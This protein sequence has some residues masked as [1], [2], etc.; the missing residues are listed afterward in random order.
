[1]SYAHPYRG[2]RVLDLGQGVAAPYCAQLLA[3]YGA[4]VIKVEPPEG[5]WGRSLGSTYAGRQ[6]AV[7]A[8]FNRGKK[9]LVLD[10]RKDEARAVARRLALKADILIEGF[11]PGVAARL[12]LGYESLKAENPKLL[13]VSVSGFGQQGPYAARPCSDSAAQAFSGLIHAA[14]GPDGTPHKST[15]ILSDVSTGLYAYQALAT[16]LYARRDA[17]EGRWIDVSLMTGSAA[18]LGHK[19][20][21]FMLEGGTPRLLNAPAGVYRTADGW[22]MVT[23][24]REDQFRKLCVILG[25]PGLAEDPMF[26][27]FAAR[28]DHIDKLVPIIRELLLAATTDAWL[29]KLRAADLICDRINDF[30]DWLKDGHVQAVGCAVAVEHP[31][32]GTVHVPR[33]PGA[34]PASDDTLG[35]APGLGEHSRSVLADA[36]W[37]DAEIDGLIAA[38]AV[39]A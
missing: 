29:E 31:G 36:G 14:R 1:M 3:T 32:V 8:V 21:E 19:L 16:A 13:Y 4:E 37:S 6:S 18:L 26:A 2:L 23:L 38:G 10:L 22:I 20:A 9:S 24:V 30:G 27:T 34:E 11:R 5:D 17:A 12:G 33:T 28:A 39:A 25:R 7:S 35:L 15:A